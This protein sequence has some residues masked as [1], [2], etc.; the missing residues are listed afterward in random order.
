[1]FRFI[2]F[3]QLTATV[4]LLPHLNPSYI[5]DRNSDLIQITYWYGSTPEFHPFA[6]L[7]FLLL[8]LFFKE[9]PAGLEHMVNLL[10][11]RNRGRL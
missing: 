4:P 2:A 9:T 6:C 3:T 10:R 1:M 8:T 7:R 5:A 11:S